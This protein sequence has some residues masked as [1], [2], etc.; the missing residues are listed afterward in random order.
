MGDEYMHAKNY[1]CLIPPYFVNKPAIGNMYQI[2][3]LHELSRISRLS[4]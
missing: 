4:A 2:I 3:F 1:G